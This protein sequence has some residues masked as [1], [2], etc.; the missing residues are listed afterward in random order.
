MQIDTSTDFGHRVSRRLKDEI[1]IWLTTTDS[2]GTPQ[3]RPVWFLWD[4]ETF[5][6]Y[7][8]PGTHKLAH[9][10]ANPRVA[11][12]FDGDGHGGDIAVF[13]GTATLQ[14]GVVPSEHGPDYIQKYR[15]DIRGIDM[16]VESFSREYT[17]AIRVTPDKLRGE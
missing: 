2:N 16:T 5:L 14:E 6:I 15:S 9:I 3:P 11:L 10:R 13:T 4:G 8:M 12:N 17:V 7:S 1:V